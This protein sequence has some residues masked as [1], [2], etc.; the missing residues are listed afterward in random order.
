[1]ELKG[2]GGVVRVEENGRESGD[3]TVK[4]PWSDGLLLTACDVV[5]IVK[6]RGIPAFHSFHSFH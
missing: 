4:L 5:A 1:M 3:G 6:D 2:V